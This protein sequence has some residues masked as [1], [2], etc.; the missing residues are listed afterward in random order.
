VIREADYVERLAYTRTQAAEALGVSRSTFIRRV[1]P[2]VETIEMAWGARLIP[3]DEL[4]RLVVENRRAAQ[5]TAQPAA[6]GRPPLVSADVVERICDA[7]AAARAFDG[8]Q[9]TSTPTKYRQRTVDAAG[10]RRPSVPS[11]TG[12]APAAGRE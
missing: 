1:L 6:P 10:G 2:Y 12:P 9:R 7:H 8:S 11:S 4:E 5:A 3:A